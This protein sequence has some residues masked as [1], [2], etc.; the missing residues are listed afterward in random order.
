MHLLFMY[1]HTFQNVDLSL[2]ELAHASTVHYYK[3]YVIFLSHSN[4]F[5]IVSNRKHIFF[6][7][8]KT[9]AL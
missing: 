2:I 9:I 4:F 8:V 3:R 5:M 7:C 6:N 1:V